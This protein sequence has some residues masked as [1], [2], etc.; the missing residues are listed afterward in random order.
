MTNYPK[1]EKYQICQ[2]TSL[3]KVLGVANFMLAELN[4]RNKTLQP[5]INEFLKSV[6]NEVLN[7]EELKEFKQLEKL[8]T[9]KSKDKS[10]TEINQNNKSDI[11]KLL[12]EQE[13]NILISKMI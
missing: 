7:E 11:S 5:N 1:I 10:V 2:M 8:N 6:K 9:T 12:S 4:Y 13:Y 3:T